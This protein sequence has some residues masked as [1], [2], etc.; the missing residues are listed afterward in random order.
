MACIPFSYFSLTVQQNC[1]IRLDTKDC[2]KE[3]LDCDSISLVL[4]SLI[5]FQSDVSTFTS[6]LS[7][8]YKCRHF[9][10]SIEKSRFL[11]SYLLEKVA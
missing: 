6:E 7:F 8:I 1:A 5:R 2:P 3:T 11:Q 4:D 9:S 10:I